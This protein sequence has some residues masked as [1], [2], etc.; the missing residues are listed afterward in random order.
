VGSRAVLEQEPL[1]AAWSWLLVLLLSIFAIAPLTYPGFFEASSGFLPAFNAAHPQQAPDW[2]GTTPAAQGEGQLPYL[3]TWPF[4][5]LSGSG[6]VAVKWGYGLAFALGALG[7]YAWSRRWLGSG[8]GVLAAAVY[9]YLPWH[10]GTVYERGAYAEAWLWAFW[11]CLLWSIDHLSAGRRA[12]RVAA[13]AVGLLLLGAILWT[14]PGLA[15]LSLPVLLA[16]GVIADPR[17]RRPAIATILVIALALLLLWVLAR[18]DT[19][20]QSLYQADYLYPFQLFS[21]R[22]TLGGNA[23]QAADQPSFQ[24]GVAAAG[25]AL[26]AVALWLTG[27]R[28]KPRGLGAVLGFWAVALAVFLSLTLAWSARLWEFAGL[29]AFV[30]HPW[31][32][33]AVA[34][35]PLAFLSG[36][37][38]RLDNRLAALPAW[39]GLLSLVVL[40]SYFYLA[41]EFTQV[42]PGTDPSAMFQPVSASQPA[43]VLLDY[44][45]NEPSELEPTL[46]VTLTWQALAPLPDD[47]TVFLHVLRGA[48][49]KVAQRDSQPCDGACPTSTWVPGEIVVDRHQIALPEGAESDPLRL[50]LGLYLLDSGQRAAVAGDGDTVIL[51]A[52]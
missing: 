15:L 35:L 13:G 1:A 4:L 31:Q 47:Y 50:A 39:A 52:R 28:G 20:T 34:G 19:G 48:D 33:L 5:H 38:L 6:V 43:I 44:Q 22:W 8:G 16:Y 3:L 49:E 46:A 27:R 11:P 32:L 9:T 26:V 29:R 2:A 23:V 10:L 37:L 25:L 7:V 40:S 51:D 12:Y 45:M 30:V 21:A 18:V 41:P 17:R 42:D 24:L 14:Q 36:S